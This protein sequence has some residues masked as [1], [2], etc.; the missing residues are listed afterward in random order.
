PTIA[1]AAV[2]G[3]GFDR[4]AWESLAAENEAAAQ[5][6]RNRLDEE[7]PNPANLFGLTNWKSPEEVKIA[8]AALGLKLES[9][10]DEA[11]SAL[12]HPPA[13]L[14]REYRASSKLADTYGRE[15]LRH[16]A[17]DGRV[18]AG[19]RQIGAGVSGRMSCSGPNLQQLPRDVRFRRCF[20]A[21][22]GRVL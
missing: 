17:A 22:P 11:L 5:T 8:F 14:L 21:P 3:V 6:F 2:K 13:E 9:T 20:V 16:V 18:Y 1:W 4:A 10:D 15:W 7:A 12:A 19:W